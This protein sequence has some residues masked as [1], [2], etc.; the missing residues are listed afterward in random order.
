MFNLKDLK[1][2]DIKELFETQRLGVTTMNVFFQNIRV[3]KTRSYKYIS[4]DTYKEYYMKMMDDIEI[5]SSPIDTI[6]PNA[7]EEEVPQTEEEEFKSMFSINTLVPEFGLVT[8]RVTL[9]D[10]YEYIPPTNGT[11]QKMKE[12]P[13]DLIKMKEEL[14][15]HFLFTK[16]LQCIDQVHLELISV[17]SDTIE[18]VVKNVDLKTLKN[19]IHQSKINFDKYKEKLKTLTFNPE[20]HR[21]ITFYSDPHD[22]IPVID[23]EKIMGI[24]FTNSDST[25]DDVIAIALYHT[26]A[27]AI[28]DIESDTPNDQFPHV[29]YIKEV[30][31]KIK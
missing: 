21:T 10:L 5:T 1:A 17:F 8:D 23:V 15:M 30:L 25:L 7:K 19:Y 12:H 22:D 24:L 26:L 11:Y 31:S 28:I 27:Y 20:Y 29:V 14:F 9:D 18:Y 4:L 13:E 2:K 6:V 16:Y 3:L